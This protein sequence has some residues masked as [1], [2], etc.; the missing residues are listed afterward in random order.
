MKEMA[1]A[2]LGARRAKPFWEQVVNPLE[3]GPCRLDM[4]PV[5]CRLQFHS[6]S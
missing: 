5:A 2:A 4:A 1:S 6:L 3:F